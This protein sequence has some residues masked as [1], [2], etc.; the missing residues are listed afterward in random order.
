MGSTIIIYSQ[1]KKQT[2]S[3]PKEPRQLMINIMYLVLTAMLALNVSAE[4]FNAFKVLDQGLVQSNL[5][6]DSSNQP[7][8]QA[9][10]EAAKAKPSFQKY[11]DRVE[12]IRKEAQLLSDYISAIKDSLIAESGGFVLDPDTQ[13]YTEALVGEKNTDVTTRILVDNPIEEGLADGIGEELRTK[14][15][16]F[17]SNIANYIDKEDIDNFRTNIAINIDD[18]T[19]KEA[20]KASWSHMNFEYMPVQAVIPIFNKYINDV[21]STEAAVLNYLGKKVGIGKED[22]VF[23][24]FTVVAAP[25]K[26]YVIKGE[27]YTADVFLTASAGSDSRTKVELSINGRPLQVDRSGIGQYTINT[28]TPGPQTYTAVAKVYNPV[29]EKTSTYKKNFTYEVGERSVAISPTKMNVFY[30]G[31]DNPVEISAAGTNSNT[32]QV[33]MSGAGGGSIKKAANGT[34]VVNV[35]TPTGKNET[36]KV[37]VIAEGMNV[38]KEFRVKRIP[39]PIPQLSKSKGGSMSRGEFKLQKGLFAVLENFDFEASCDIKEFKLVR[40]PK[41][42]DATVVINKG[43]RYTSKATALVQKTKTSD[44]FYF[45]DIKCKCPGDTRLRDLGLMLFHIK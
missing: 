11:A 3:I 16:A 24:D 12:P 6:L 19:W 27:P 25:E 39:D 5:A 45:E 35:K 10:Y 28:S 30:I 37:N 42:G 21:K 32:L 13:Q 43:G 4:I 41:R 9:I 8:Q 15:L 23:G 31:V 14:L 38:T 44:K 33:N 17:K 40:V 34:F 2:M 1:L 20:G 22:V 26:S 36:A 7:M 18:S 29:T